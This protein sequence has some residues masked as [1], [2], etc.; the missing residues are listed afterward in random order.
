MFSFPVIGHYMLVISSIKMGI[1]PQQRVQCKNW[2]HQQL[3]LTE[4]P[5][6][7]M[8]GSILE[9]SWTCHP[10]KNA[11]LYSNPIDA[12]N[13]TFWQTQKDFNLGYLYSEGGNSRCWIQIY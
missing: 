10:V 11:L 2:H 3:S 13:F 8:N 5:Q 7:C 1:T 12:S 6:V 4:L 9:F